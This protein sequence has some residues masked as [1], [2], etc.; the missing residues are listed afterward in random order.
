M[1]TTS[2]KAQLWRIV[3]RSMTKTIMLSTDP[4]SPKARSCRT[5]WNPFPT[6]APQCRVVDVLCIRFRQKKRCRSSW[7][8]SAFSR[9]KQR[10][11]AGSNRHLGRLAQRHD[12][13]F[14]FASDFQAGHR[15]LLDGGLVLVVS[16]AE[17]PSPSIDREGV[18]R[19]AAR[20]AKRLCVGK[21]E[22]VTEAQQAAIL[23][24]NPGPLLLRFTPRLSIVRR[25][26]CR[27]VPSPSHRDRWLQLCPA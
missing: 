1:R 27:A 23:V 16:I 4:A 12:L 21:A 2:P 25:S 9:R 6:T 11:A 10:R 13:R 8:C 7:Y 17:S 19:G 26:S 14:R 3:P 22:I 15:A 18:G 5:S 20:L 24:V